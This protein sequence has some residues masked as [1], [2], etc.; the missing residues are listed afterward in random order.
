[1]QS[2]LMCSRCMAGQSS[3]YLIC[4]LILF[5]LLNKLQTQHWYI[6]ILIIFHGEIVADLFYILLFYCSHNNLS[7]K[8]HRWL[9]L[10]SVFGQRD[11]VNCHLFNEVKK[12][13][14]CGL[15]HIFCFALS[16]SYSFLNNYIFN[17][18]N[19]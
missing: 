12:C 10:W 8:H 9:N 3:T 2:L 15:R 14:Y 11:R 5:W 19:I 7:S 13:G 17:N 6:I 16:W 4:T 18:Q 1:M